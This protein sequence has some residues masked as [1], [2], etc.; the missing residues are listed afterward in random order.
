MRLRR[1]Y[2][3][4]FEVSETS[5]LS[6]FML[7]RLVSRSRR[8][9]F[10]MGRKGALT[11]KIRMPGF[12]SQFR[13]TVTGLTEGQDRAKSLVGRNAFVSLNSVEGGIGRRF[14]SADRQKLANVDIDDAELQP[15]NW[16]TG[17]GRLLLPFMGFPV[18]EFLR[19]ANRL[20]ASTTDPY[21]QFAPTEQE[22]LETGWNLVGCVPYGIYAAGKMPGR[23]LSGIELVYVILVCDRI[24]ISLPLTQEYGMVCPTDQYYGG[25]QLVMKVSFVRPIHFCGAQDADDLSSYT[26]YYKV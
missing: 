4:L 25:G 14:S 15:K 18:V 11:M 2:L 23:P 16:M 19:A 21:R 10:I 13:R 6:T 9:H 12:V 26:V 7:S 22:Q 20:F 3:K 17:E 1:I 5:L 24:G 8:K